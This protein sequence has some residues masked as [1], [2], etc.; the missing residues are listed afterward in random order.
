MT[1]EKKKA[2]P[3]PE[4]KGYKIL[5]AIPKLDDKFENSRIVRADSHKKREETA[6]IVGFV[7]KL[8][9][10]AYKDEDK[11]P[12]GPWCK[13]GD[14]IIMRAYSGTRFLVQTEEGEQEFRLINDDMVEAV[15]ADPRGITR[16]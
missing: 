12:D 13:E 1:E 4:P 8:G 2:L 3:L 16:A 5:I 6:S 7:T 10:I 14:F 11:F 9:S 15:V